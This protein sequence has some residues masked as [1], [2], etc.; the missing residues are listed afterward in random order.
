[1]HFLLHLLGLDD[2][3]GRPYLFWSGIAADV[4]ELAIFGGLFGVYR[5]HQCHVHGCWRFAKFPIDGTPYSSC[6]RH[7][8]E[9]R[10]RITHEHLVDAWRSRNTDDAGP[11]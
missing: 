6:S 5:R 11:V 8:P 3:S 4:S 1:M 9:L 7:H 2:A 10:D